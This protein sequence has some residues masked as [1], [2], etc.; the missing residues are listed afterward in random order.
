MKQASTAKYIMH[1]YIAATGGQAAL[2]GVQSMYAVGKVKMCASEFHLGDQTVTAA[3]G[4]AEVGGFVLWQKCPEVW[5][6]ELIMA[7]HKMSAGSD[8]KVAWRQSAA[9]NSHASRG[10]PRPLR[11][12]LQAR[13][14]IL[15]IGL[16]PRS[17]ANLFSDAVCIGEKVINGEECFI[18]KL[19]AS[20]ATLRARSAAAFDII[21]HTVWGYFSQRTGLLIQLEDNHLLRMKSGKGARRSENIFWETSMELRR[22]RYYKHGSHDPTFRAYQTKHMRKLNMSEYRYLQMKKAEK[23]DY[24]PDPAEGTRS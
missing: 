5:Y 10:P 16:D 19:E 20:A 9:E 22:A 23:P 17:I 13:P 1:Q 12:S 2:Q 4:R 6:F 15:P 14:R 8:G 3:Q 7:G 21:H 24:L 11:R 18:L